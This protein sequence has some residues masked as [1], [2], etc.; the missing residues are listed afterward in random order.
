MSGTESPQ[1][2]NID[3]VNEKSSS[4]SLS[5]QNLEEENSNLRKQVYDF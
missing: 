3:L 2:E 4:N 1:K 5:N